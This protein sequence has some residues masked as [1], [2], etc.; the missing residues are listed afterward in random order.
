MHFVHWCFNFTYRIKCASICIH[1]GIRNQE[2][3]RADGKRTAV[4]I[5]TIVGEDFNCREEDDRIMSFDSAI[6]H[7]S[8]IPFL[9]PLCDCS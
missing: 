7:P 3:T 2:F 5:I 4:K 6:S 9:S 8:F 1:R